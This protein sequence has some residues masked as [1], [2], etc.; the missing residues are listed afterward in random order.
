LSSFDFLGLG[1]MPNIKD[2]SR[3]ALEFYGCGSCGPRGFYGTMDLHLKFETEIAKFMGTA[4][5][6]FMKLEY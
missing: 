1:Q 5:L 4:V 6:F 2:T 3:S